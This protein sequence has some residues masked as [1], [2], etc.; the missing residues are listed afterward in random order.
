MGQQAV[1]LEEDVLTLNKLGAFVSVDGRRGDNVIHEYDEGTHI[2]L[3]RT[4]RD[5]HQS[6]PKVAVRS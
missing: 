4:L 6:L 1:L 5:V 2:R 3:Q